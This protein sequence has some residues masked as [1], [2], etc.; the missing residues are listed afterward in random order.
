M[1]MA[2]LNKNAK[3][4][5]TLLFTKMLGFFFFLLNDL[6]VQLKMWLF[7]VINITSKTE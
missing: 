7:L 3:K 1:F 4:V 2:G 5:L 6:K